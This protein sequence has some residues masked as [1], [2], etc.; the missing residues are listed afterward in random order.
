M[1]QNSFDSLKAA[2]VSPAIL[3]F[4]RYDQPFKLYTDA[5][6]FSV[7]AVLC[8]EQDGIERVISYAGRS[9]SNSESNIEYS[10][11]GNGQTQNDVQLNNTDNIVNNNVDDEVFE[12]E[13]ILRKKYI[14]GKWLYRVKWQ[15]FDAKHN[16]C[17]Q[18]SDLNK[19]CQEYVTDMH[20]RIFTDRKS[21]MK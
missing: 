15:D 6:S 4:P 18:F 16:S 11:P 19:K 3:G 9:L 10:Q 21:Q 14:N 2:L 17:V 12:V 20:D 13:K 7:G 1:C 5:S 8:Q